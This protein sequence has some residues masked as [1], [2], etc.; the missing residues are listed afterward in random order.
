[1][2]TARE[3]VL[4]R[5]RAALGETASPALVDA[6]DE[7]AAGAKGSPLPEVDEAARR[8]RFVERVSEYGAAVLPVLSGEIADVVATI[9]AEHGARTVAC[10]VDIPSSWRPPAIRMAPDDPALSFADLDRVDGVLTG[11][12]L[13]AAETGTLALDHGPRQGRRALTLLPDLHICV[14][15]ATQLVTDVPDLIAGLAGAVDE[16]RPLTLI[17]GPS[18]TSDIEL[19]RVEGVHGPRRLEVVLVE[20]GDQER[21]SSS[22]DQ[23][24]RAGGAT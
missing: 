17:S 1:V 21:R 5:V 2:Q 15:E 23:R 24:Q 22:D 14:V 4:G 19:D 11:C 3:E 18:A 13:A 6:A 9:C 20:S 16:R 7:R 10:P 8:E 12:A